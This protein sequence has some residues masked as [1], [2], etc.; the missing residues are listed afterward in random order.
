[1][2]HPPVNAKQTPRATLVQRLRSELDLRVGTGTRQQPRTSQH[3]WHEIS[4]MVARFQQLGMWCTALQ[5]CSKQRTLRAEISKEC[6]ALNSH[7]QNSSEKLCF[8][9]RACK[10][11][12]GCFSERE[13]AGCA[14]HL[15]AQPSSEPWPRGL[16]WERG[17]SGGMQSHEIP[18]LPR[19]YRHSPESPARSIWQH[20]TGDLQ[21]GGRG[22][23]SF[24]LKRPCK[25]CNLAGGSCYG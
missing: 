11:S 1:M 5:H 18:P 12:S 17:A 15:A 7:L 8:S 3:N 25:H 20:R 24:K 9:E 6:V 2:P 10:M 13:T 23:A 14:A 19:P 16:W 21:V 22:E 4:F